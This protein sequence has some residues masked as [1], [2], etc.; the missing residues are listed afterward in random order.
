[1]GREGRGEWG[2]RW[3]CRTSGNVPATG[4]PHCDEDADAR[5]IRVNDDAKR[6]ALA[7]ELEGPDR[8]DGL[9]SLAI[10][11]V[12]WKVSLE[13][14]LPMAAL[15]M[16]GNLLVDSVDEFVAVFELEH[17]LEGKDVV[18]KFTSSRRQM[19]KL[20]FS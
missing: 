12:T 20:L 1:M 14:K 2:W 18:V 7:L 17:L 4:W 9:G 10:I 6:V 15:G 5:R 3:R 19:R 8:H 13:H 16:D 11:L